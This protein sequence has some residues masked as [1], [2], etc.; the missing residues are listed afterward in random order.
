MVHCRGKD[1]ED[2]EREA[3]TSVGRVGRG[4]VTVTLGMA[5]KGATP[6]LTHLGRWLLALGGSGLALPSPLHHFQALFK[7]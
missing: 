2:L 7:D 3:G 5:S 6:A 4:H 1:L